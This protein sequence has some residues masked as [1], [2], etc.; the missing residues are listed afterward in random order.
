[1]RTCF[2]IFNFK[3]LTIFITIVLFFS[4]S[5]NILNNNKIENSST[6]EIINISNTEN[7]NNLID[8]NNAISN[9]WKLEIPKI[10]LIADIAEGT[11]SE[12]LNQ[13]IGHFEETP[14]E[15]GNIALAAHN[16][17]YPV[18]YF[19]DLKD[20]EIDDEIYYIYNG[21]KNK[22]IVNEK[23]I[24]KDTEVEILE[25]TN[26]DILTLITC[27]ENMPEYRRCIQANKLGR[28]NE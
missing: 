8:K 19:K 24:I 4:I 22:Y 2:K 14:K 7:I 9:E 17:G 13:Y 5:K 26:E 27:V 23:K 18:N 3:I 11:S 20:L 12:I 1:M 10:N 28:E 16:R 6:N 21:I 25:N 15:S